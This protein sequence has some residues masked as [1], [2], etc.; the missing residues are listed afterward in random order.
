MLDPKT[1]TL[2]PVTTPATLYEVADL[3]TK[4]FDILSTFQDEVAAGG[5]EDEA[6]ADLLDAI[7][8]P[9]GLDGSLPD[10]V[11]ELA[12]GYAD[13]RQPDEMIYRAEDF[14]GNDEGEASE[15]GAEG[16]QA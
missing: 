5:D 8:A 12:D 16:G 2:H 11:T 3:I 14:E 9:F 15:D 10:A 7:E 6:L 1:L 13:G 4:A